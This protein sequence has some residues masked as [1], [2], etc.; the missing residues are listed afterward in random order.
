MEHK[1]IT[2]ALKLGLYHTERAAER[3]RILAK[4]NHDEGMHG[5]AADWEAEAAASTYV[6]EL[7]SNVLTKLLKGD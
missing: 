2:D 4:R 3:A 6:A 1:E 5:I 7:I